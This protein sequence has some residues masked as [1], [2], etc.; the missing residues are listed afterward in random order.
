MLSAKEGVSVYNFDSPVKVFWP[1]S[2]FA[3][4]VN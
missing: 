3:I 4:I 1:I 2:P